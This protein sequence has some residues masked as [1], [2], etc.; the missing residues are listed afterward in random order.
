MFNILV[1][2]CSECPN[3][4]K[5]IFLPNSHE[6]YIMCNKFSL[7]LTDVLT[8]HKDCKLNE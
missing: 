7:I 4:S 6:K 3:K 1:T 8:I 5:D 2:K